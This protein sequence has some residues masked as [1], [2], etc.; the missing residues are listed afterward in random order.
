MTTEP[1][2]TVELAHPTDGKAP[3]ER[4]E[5]S[6]ARAKLLVR[7]GRAKAATVAD[8]KQL[9]DDPATAATKQGKTS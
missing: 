6:P 8:A 4:I 7:S 5:V 1:T 3:G 2:V 9:G